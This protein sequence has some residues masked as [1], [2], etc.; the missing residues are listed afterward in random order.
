MAASQQALR[1]RSGHLAQEQYSAK[2]LF[3]LDDVPCPACRFPETRRNHSNQAQHAV[4]PERGNR[5]GSAAAAGYAGI[6]QLAA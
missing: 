3:P 5:Y 1:L 6:A 2:S 4:F